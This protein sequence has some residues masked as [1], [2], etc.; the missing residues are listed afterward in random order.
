MSIVMTRP[1][2]I[3]SVPLNIRRSYYYPYSSYYPYS[4]AYPYSTSYPTYPYSYPQPS[5]YGTCAAVS[6]VGVV[7]NDCLPGTTAVVTSGNGCYCHDP[8][9]GWRGCG[10]TSN[11]VCRLPTTAGTVVVT[12]PASIIAAP[13]I[14]Y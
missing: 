5:F 6:G 3:T 13:R 2:T 10:N 11:G 8:A 14:W 7:N 12:P 9:T 1:T 4:Y